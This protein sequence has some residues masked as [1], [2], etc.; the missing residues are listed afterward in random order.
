MKMSFLKNILVISALAVNACG[1]KQAPVDDGINFTVK[2]LDG[3]T[4]HL[5]DFRGKTV[6]L[7]I[8]ATWCAP[9][10]REIPELKE[11]YTEQRN[12]DIVVLGVL[13]DSDSP[14]ASKPIVR[15]EL[16][17]NYPV[18]YGDDALAQQFNVQAFPTTVII[19]KNGKKIKTMIGM[20]TK[21]KFLSALKEAAGG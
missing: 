6:L 11:I 3:K 8:W 2:D 21:E 9:C 17:I 1:K 12:N 4:V 20:Q 14:E 7:N 5:S 16:Q 15:N 19:D 10:K 18:W 13:L